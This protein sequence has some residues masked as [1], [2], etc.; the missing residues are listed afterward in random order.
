MK[1]KSLSPHPS[2]I[3]DTLS[4]K[5]RGIKDERVLEERTFMFGEK[6]DA[7][8]TPAGSG[9]ITTI[10]DRDTQ[11]E[12]KLTFEGCVQING[13]FKGE[14]FSEGALIVGEGGL[15]EGVIEIGRVE[16]KGEVQGTIRAKDRIEINAPAIVRGD[17]AAPSLIIKEGAVF[18]G[19]CSMG[20]R[21]NVV[22]LPRKT[23]FL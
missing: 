7:L 6:L 1:F 14:I 21:D 8:R 3:R 11:F 12:G 2:R 4:H 18:E 20:R 5:G 17:I 15:V 22:D 23:E 19:N 10:L 13:K 9:Q 16:I